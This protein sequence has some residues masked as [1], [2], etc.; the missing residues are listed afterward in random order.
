MRC[1]L[2]F[3]FLLLATLTLSVA[4]IRPAGAQSADLQL[5]KLDSPDPVPA[6]SSI[7]YDIILTNAGPDTAEFVSLEDTV[8]AGTTFVS[9]F[10][11]DP[12]WTC[13]T[14]MVG[15]AGGTVSCSIDSLAADTGASFTMIVAVDAGVTPGT[16]ITNT[17]TA[18]AETPDPDEGGPSASAT[19]TVAA[20]PPGADLSVTKVDDP[21]PVTPGMNLVYTITVDNGGPDAATSVNLVDSLPPGTTF[22]SLS[23]PGGWSCTTPAMGDVGDIA[24][25]IPSFAVG[26]AVFTLTVA[27][28]SAAPGSQISNAATVSSSS[29]D[30]NEG[31]NTGTAS[32]TVVGAGL[33]VTKVDNPDPVAAGQNVGYTI[34]VTNAGP[35]D[36]VDVVLTDVLP[37]GTTYG[38]SATPAAWS[39]AASPG[40]D[41]FTC[42]ISSFPPGNAV[43]IL[44][45]FVGPTVPTGTVLTNTATV[46]SATADPDPD[47]N[48]GMATTTVINGALLSGTKSVS[49]N[50]S[51]GG[52]IVYTVVLQNAGASAQADNP[53]AELT[54]VLPA[55]L[56]LVSATATSGTATATVATN[57]VTWN[58]SLAAGASVTITINAT[59]NSGVAPGTTISNQGTIA[60]DAD[61]NGTNE[62]SAV[63]DDPSTATA[64]DPT[65]FQVAAEPPPAEIPALDGFGL[66]VLAALLSLGGAWVLRRRQT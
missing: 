60:Y 34:T 55:S 58:G 10:A 3:S 20:P 9:F 7:N 61:G 47:D 19:T 8:P 14:P 13:S 44:A 38:G 27:V 40:G 29:E 54:D 63:T 50:E 66:A 16:V 1:S 49:G 41:T 33:S 15:S 12:A 28:D 53:G 51:P 42:S 39:C 48:T 4:A 36:A 11:T 32:T 52:S 24:C 59:I 2:R 6:G 5:V 25:S 57:T 37:A 30:P 18:S 65:S 43:F 22:V 46:T 56:T 17:A 35:S 23:S 31:N 64:N 62:A 45:A 21:D 26:S